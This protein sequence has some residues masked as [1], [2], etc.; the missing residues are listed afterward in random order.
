M[1]MK[2]YLVLILDLC[3]RGDAAN[4]VL[5]VRGWFCFCDEHQRWL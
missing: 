1:L 5:A 4:K 3:C 2:P